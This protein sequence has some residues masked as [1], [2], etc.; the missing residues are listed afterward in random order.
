MLTMTVRGES[1]T[2]V[3]RV[4]MT[5]PKYHIFIRKAYFN[6]PHI[7]TN[8]KNAQARMPCVLNICAH[9]VLSVIINFRV[10]FLI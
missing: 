7:F 8:F 6:E 3:T 1:L 4:K 5:D 9:F 10:F 2:L